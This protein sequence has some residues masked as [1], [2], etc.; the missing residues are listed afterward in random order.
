MPEPG[1]EP[2]HGG[3]S[4]EPPRI[5]GIR[6][7]ETSD[8][9]LA[10][11]QSP[12]HTEGYVR[13]LRWQP[14][15]LIAPFAM[16]AALA[17]TPILPISTVP[18]KNE[19]VVCIDPGHS[20]LAGGRYME[21]PSRINGQT[22]TLAEWE[23]NRDVS[24]EVA[25]QLRSR[26]DKQ[27]VTIVLTWG[28]ID[29]RSRPWS[30]SEGPVSDE[31]PAVMMRGWFCEQQGARLVVSLHTNGLI[32][33]EP[34]NGTLTGFHDEDDLALADTLHWLL[35]DMMRRTHSNKIII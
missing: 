17:L 13:L 20:P 30:A 16:M 11:I 26:Y 25:R 18:E 35:L 32:D 7:T 23:I 21:L 6:G 2:L 29:G 8:L 34:L 15:R 31:R 12:K 28:E 22:L 10:Y 9:A 14:P 33:N 1:E 19:L 27:A 5:V 4:R 3:R 24:L